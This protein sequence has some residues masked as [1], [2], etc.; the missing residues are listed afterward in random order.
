M[1]ESAAAAGPLTPDRTER[2]SSRVVSLDALR[3]IVV[4]LMI[5]MDHPVVISALPDFLVHPAW[6]GFRLPD[7][8]FP[9]FVFIAGVSMAF[10]T[11]KLTAEAFWPATRVFVK[12]IALLFLIGVALNFG[13]YSLALFREGLMEPF[14]GLRYMG[15]LQ[16]IALGVLAAWPF[17]RRDARWALAAAGGLMLAH[18]A[19]LLAVGAPGVEAGAWVPGAT[20]EDVAAVKE[21]TIAGWIDR[22]VMG[23]DHTYLRSGF[24]PEGLLGVLTTAAQAILGLALGKL[25][26]RDAHSGRETGRMLAWG[27][28]GVLLAIALTPLLPINKYLWTATFVLVSSGVATLVLALMYRYVDV[29][30]HPDRFEWLVPMGRNALLLYICSNIFVIALR[31]IPLPMP[32]G[33][34]GQTF[35]AIGAWGSTV[36]PPAMASLLFSGAEVAM[37]F[38]VAKVL[39]DRKLFFKL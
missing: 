6:H 25:L 11:R 8:V 2:A 23:A 1:R 29:A 36:M 27:A 5:F 39:Y 30:G 24:D 14:T 9:A 33:G 17:V 18:S 3:A 35:H 15:V 4:A 31:V 22:T 34:W 16:R 28:G 37:W 21:A 38:A 10:S 7:F 12:R 13:K 26:L 32:E 19:V 20:A